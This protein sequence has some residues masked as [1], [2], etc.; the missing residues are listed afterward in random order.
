MS[1][2]TVGAELLAAKQRLQIFKNN[3]TVFGS[4]RIKPTDPLYNDAYELGK[5]I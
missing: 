5:F 2:V 3:V 4:A 1:L